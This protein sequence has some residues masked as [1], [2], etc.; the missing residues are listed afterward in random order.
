MKQVLDK[1]FYWPAICDMVMSFHV[2]AG[3]LGD[4]QSVSDQEVS[5]SRKENLMIGYFRNLFQFRW[6]FL[7]LTS[8][9]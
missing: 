8:Y 5:V 2:T 7:C 3:F 4:K 9:K 6:V 1:S